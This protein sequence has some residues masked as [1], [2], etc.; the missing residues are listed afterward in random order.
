[1]VISL[2][3]YN[4]FKD[5]TLNAPLKDNKVFYNKYKRTHLFATKALRR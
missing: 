5:V 4:I 1:M 3:N 2:L